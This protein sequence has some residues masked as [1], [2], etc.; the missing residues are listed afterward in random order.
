MHCFVSIAVLASDSDE[1][2]DM[3]HLSEALR[4][5]FHQVLR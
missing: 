2:T 4:D 1:H 3:P 5:L